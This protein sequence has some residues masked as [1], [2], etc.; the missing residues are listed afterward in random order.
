MEKQEHTPG[1][2]RISPAGGLIQPANGSPLNC[3]C[4]G[5]GRDEEPFPNWEANSRLIAAA[6]ELLDA[7]QGALPVVKHFV[8]NHDFMLIEQMEAAIAKATGQTE[9]HDE[10]EP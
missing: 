8:K 2:W 5:F 10:Q 9:T 6:P 4:R 3:I 1:P 7:L